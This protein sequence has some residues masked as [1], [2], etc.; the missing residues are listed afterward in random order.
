M[1]CSQKLARQN[2]QRK[3]ILIFQHSQLRKAQCINWV[4]EG[5]FLRKKLNGSCASY[6]F[7][8]LECWQDSGPEDFSAPFCSERA[9]NISTWQ[10]Q[11]DKTLNSSQWVPCPPVLTR[12]V[13]MSTSLVFACLSGRLELEDLFFFQKKKDKRQTTTSHRIFTENLNCQTPF[14][15]F[16]TH[17][18]VPRVISKDPK[19]TP[20]TDPETS[21]TSQTE[22]NSVGSLGLPGRFGQMR[23][24]T[25]GGEPERLEVTTPDGREAVRPWG[26]CWDPQRTGLRN[27]AESNSAQKRPGRQGDFLFEKSYLFFLI[28]KKKYFFK[29]SLIANQIPSVTVTL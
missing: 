12:F 16:P 22:G 7:S 4:F 15:G 13:E 29:K 3:K 10:W 6:N 19:R 8:C 9:W 1:V 2:K 25:S 5:L 21:E 18:G 20:E 24:S 14:L 11:G 26:N 27:I 28:F 23:L 17:S